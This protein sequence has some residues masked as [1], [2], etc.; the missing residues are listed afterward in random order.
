MSDIALPDHINPARWPFDHQ[1][2]RD[3]AASIAYPDPPSRTVY[4]LRA[5]RPRFS[6]R[7]WAERRRHAQR[8]LA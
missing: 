4:R 8:M 7:E 6:Q 5:G 2:A 3:R 1:R